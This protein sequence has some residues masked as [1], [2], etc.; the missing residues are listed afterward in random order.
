[1]QCSAGLDPLVPRVMK[2]AVSRVPTFFEP[3]T[4]ATTTTDFP[5]LCHDAAFRTYGTDYRSRDCWYV[6][7]NIAHNKYKDGDVKKIVLREEYSCA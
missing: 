6:H 1:M 3:R 2:I 5:R 7:V 4:T